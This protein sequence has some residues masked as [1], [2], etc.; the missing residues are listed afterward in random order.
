MSEAKDIAS[1][2]EI[3]QLLEEVNDLV[4]F[5]YF[6]G[7]PEEEPEEKKLTIVWKSEF[8]PEIA[9][10]PNNQKKHIKCSRTLFT[11]LNDRVIK[12]YKTKSIDWLVKVKEFEHDV[13]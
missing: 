9:K 3:D 7:E 11:F 13:R 2:H 5:G 6:K 4:N 8:L 12:K 1:D 10:S